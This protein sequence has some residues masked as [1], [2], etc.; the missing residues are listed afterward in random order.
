MNQF[1]KAFI[2]IIGLTALVA[3]SALL[4]GCTSAP[5]HPGRAIFER[6]CARCHN[7]SRPLAKTKTREGWQRTVKVMKKRGARLTDE[8]VKLV[9]DYLV[10]VRG[11]G[12]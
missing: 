1:T 9:V 4:S 12:E 5:H 3:L 6:A 11:A 10:T 2:L 8:E 7:I